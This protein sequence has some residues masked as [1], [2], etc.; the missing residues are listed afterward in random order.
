[1]GRLSREE[2]ARRDRNRLPTLKW[3][4]DPSISMENKVVRW[5]YDAIIKQRGILYDDIADELGITRSAVGQAFERILTTEN[6][7]Y[8]TLERLDK[9][10]SS[11]S[12]RKHAALGHTYCRGDDDTLCIGI[13]LSNDTRAAEAKYRGEYERLYGEAVPLEGFKGKRPIRGRAG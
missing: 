11:I 12:R 13:S 1:M 8:Q 2:L 3:A 7:S 4:E 10:I 9:A 6:I 5:T